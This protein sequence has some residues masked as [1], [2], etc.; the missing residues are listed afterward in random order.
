[1]KGD[2]SISQTWKMLMELGSE[3]MRNGKMTHLGI[4]PCVSLHPLCCT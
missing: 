1:M 2:A 3:D 4:R